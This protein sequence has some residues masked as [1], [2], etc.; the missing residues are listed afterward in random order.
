ML[1]SPEISDFGA[2][3]TRMSVSSLVLR[4]G[5]LPGVLC[6][7]RPDTLSF[8]HMDH[9]VMCTTYCYSCRLCWIS[10]RGGSAISLEWMTK[11]YRTK[12][13]VG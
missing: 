1:F 11:V 10:N 3:S 13:G 8:Q 7:D 5:A 2:P 9:H 6:G 12:K 4:D